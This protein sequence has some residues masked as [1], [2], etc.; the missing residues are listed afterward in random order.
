MLILNL[1]V[2]LLYVVE[3]LVKTQWVDDWI[4]GCNR[5]L[6]NFFFFLSF[7]FFVINFDKVLFYCADTFV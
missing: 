2:N 5:G 6:W 1:N 7:F 3:D 4:D